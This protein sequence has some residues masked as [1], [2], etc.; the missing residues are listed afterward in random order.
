M[1]LPESEALLEHGFEYF[2]SPETDSDEE[3]IAYLF[4]YCAAAVEE[5]PRFRREL[6]ERGAKSPKACDHLEKHAVDVFREMRDVMM[7]A[8]DTGNLAAMSEPRLLQRLVHAHAMMALHA[9]LTSL[10]GYRRMIDPDTDALSMSNRP[11]QAD[12]LHALWEAKWNAPSA[13]MPAEITRRE[14]RRSWLRHK[15]DGLYNTNGQLDPVATAVPLDPL[16]SASEPIMPLS[17]MQLGFLRQKLRALGRRAGLTKD[18]AEFLVRMALDG[19]KQEDN[20]AAWR[21]IRDRKR[22]ALLGK[23]RG[24]LVALRKNPEFISGSKSA[25]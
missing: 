3:R 10:V 19:A 13:L 8:M 21:A 20:P 23:V 4:L 7:A 15:N 12:F 9:D 16:F 1:A 5:W 6:I 22:G 11:R 24:L 18:H 14:S 2:P 17:T 25:S